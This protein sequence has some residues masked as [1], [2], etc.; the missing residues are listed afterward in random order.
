MTTL[1]SKFIKPVHMYIT[2]KFKDSQSNNTICLYAI[3]THLSMC[4]SVVNIIIIMFSYQFPT[5]PTTQ[6]GARTVHVMFTYGERSKIQGEQLD[7]ACPA[8]IITC[9]PHNFHSNVLHL[10]VGH[11]KKN[12]SQHLTY[13]SNL[14]KQTTK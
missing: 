1:Q 9:N 6:T 13:F 11:I 14:E 2:P 12:F 10:R 7:S 4:T 3:L 5:T 8:Q